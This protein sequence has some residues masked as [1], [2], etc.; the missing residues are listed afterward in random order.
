[1]IQECD[2]PFTNCTGRVLPS[3]ASACGVSIFREEWRT[4]VDAGGRGVEIV[5]DPLRFCGAVAGLDARSMISHFVP[6]RSES[7]DLKSL[8]GEARQCSNLRSLC[9]THEN[10]PDE[11]GDAHDPNE[12]RDPPTDDVEYIRAFDVFP[13]ASSFLANCWLFAFVNTCSVRQTC[14]GVRMQK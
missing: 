8:L 3:D 7:V 13:A 6:M 10:T 12:V 4:C 14:E 1:M 9:R 2:S 11:V 5:P